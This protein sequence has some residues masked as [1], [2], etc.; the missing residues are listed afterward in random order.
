MNLDHFQTRLLYNK[1]IKIIRNS[2]KLEVGFWSKKILLLVSSKCHENL[3]PK[4]PPNWQGYAEQD[5]P[6]H[7][8]IIMVTTSAEK[9][10]TN[11]DRCH[12]LQPHPADQLAMTNWSRP[13]SSLRSQLTVAVVGI[14]LCPT[15]SPKGHFQ[16][17]QPITHLSWSLELYRRNTGHALLSWKPQVTTISKTSSLCSA[18]AH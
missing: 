12:H 6:S 10:Q 18:E 8:I 7:Q 3:I 2:Q 14:M 9:I 13:F 15:L 4:D 1:K 5:F 16:F 11:N 17:F